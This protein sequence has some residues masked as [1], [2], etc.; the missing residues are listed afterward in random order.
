MLK[1]IATNVKLAVLSIVLVMS[2]LSAPP[3]FAQ[4]SNPDTLTTLL[5]TLQDDDA[6]AALISELETLAATQAPETPLE[7]VLTAPTENISIGRRIALFTQ[8][9]VEAT[10]ARA[11]A[12]WTSLTSGDSVFAG[13]SGSEFQVLIQALPNL[14][15]VIVITI[16][17]FM[18]LRRFAIPIYRRMGRH[19]NEASAISTVFL[20]ISSNLLDIFI[21]ILAWGLGYLVTVL[22]VGNFGEIGIRQTMYLNGFLIV[23]LAKSVVRIVL[24]PNSAGLR[25][26]PIQTAPAKS[27]YRT[28]AIV[29]SVLG[30]GQLLVVPIINRSASMAAGSG[31][32]ALLYLAVLCYLIVVVFRKRAPVA[33]WMSGIATLPDAPLPDDLNEADAFE[34]PVAARRPGLLARIWISLAHRWHWFALLYLA[35]MFILVMTQSNEVVFTAALAS[36]K[37]IA[38]VVIASLVSNGLSRAMVHGF[39]LP[40]DWAEKLPLL[41]PRLNKFLHRIFG[42]IR[43]VIILVA[44]LFV[45]NALEVVDLGTWLTSNFGVAASK[46]IVSVSTILAV[47]FLIWLA[48]TSWVDYRLNPEFGAIANNRE[49]TLLTLLRNAATIAIVVLTI[50]F[51]LSEIGL[52]IGPLLASAGVLGLAIG[53]GAQSM[54]QDIITGIFIQFENAMN[55]GDV[56]SVN[57]TTG[58]VEKLSVRSVS[59]RDVNGTVHLIPFSSVDMVSN[60]SRDFSYFVCDMGV[61]YRENVEEVREAM[62]LCFDQLKDDDNQGMFVIDDLEWFGLQ[63]FGDSAIVLRARIKTQPGKQFGVGRAYNGYLKTEFDARGIEIPFPHQTIFFGEAKDGSTQ[64]VNVQTLGAPDGTQT[65]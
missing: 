26:F 60:F 47:S 48:M 6:R 59:L 63:S 1:L 43:I 54:V 58:T 35:V 31:V 64:P 57:G 17:V 18:V 24:A 15:L 27:L 61:A 13:L 20:F 25:P 19:A 9:I 14:L 51:S 40:S 56:V 8:D 53:F 34:A 22:A 33:G 16:I 46:I 23:E 52:N 41:E 7:E 50:M 32:A 36:G 42:L 21:V 11:T 37:V 10:T 29:I 3:A 45:L 44:G 38:V 4:D 62:L 5:E 2:M 39:A 30:Y 55:V 49:V 65:S 12:I 28:L